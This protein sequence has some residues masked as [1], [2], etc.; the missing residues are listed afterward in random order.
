VPAASVARYRPS[1]DTWLALGS[2]VSGGMEFNSPVVNTL[3]ILSNGDIIAAGQIA[4]AE[5]IPVHN[6]A[7][8][9]PATNHWSAMSAGLDGEVSTLIALPGGD[10]VAGCWMPAGGLAQ[11]ANLAIWTT[12]PACIADFDCSGSATITDLFAFIAAWIAQSG[13]SGPGLSADA[14]NDGVVNAADLFAFIAAW[15]GGCP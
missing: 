7:R 6:V 5:A 15:F 13:A 10:L 14:T 12:R 11:F 2:G 9:T 3:A 1:D 4:A 8:Y